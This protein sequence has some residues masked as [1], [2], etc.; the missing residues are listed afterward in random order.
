M[1]RSTSTRVRPRSLLAAAVTLLAFSAGCEKAPRTLAVRDPVQRPGDAR[2]RVQLAGVT[3]RAFAGADG[4]DLV[5]EIE[6][7]PASRLLLA[8]GTERSASLRCTTTLERDG[9]AP[10]VVA[11]LERSSAEVGWL[12]QIAALPAIDAGALRLACEGPTPSR[13]G[14]PLLA[15]L[16]PSQAAPLLVLVS[17]DLLRADHVSGFGKRSELTPRLGRLG[18]HGLRMREVASDGAR[19]LPS[20]HALF[21]SK[22]HGPWSDDSR[23][24]PLAAVLAEHGVLT[25][26]LTSGSQLRTLAEGFDHFA[27]NQPSFAAVLQRA[28]SWIDASEGIA[29]FLFLHSDAPVARGDFEPPAYADRVRELDAQI[30]ALIDRLTREAERRPVLLV[31]TSGHGAALRGDRDPSLFDERIRVPLIA[32]SPGFVPAGRTSD[33]P[34]S[35]SDIAPTLLAAAGLQLPEAMT[36]A[37]LWPFWSGARDEAPAALGTLSW[38]DGTWVFRDRE[39]KLIVRTALDEPGRYAL[40]DLSHDADERVDLASEEPEALR[41]MRERLGARLAQVG[42]PPDLPENPIAGDCVVGE[43]GCLRAQG[44]PAEPRERLRSLGYLD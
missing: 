4:A 28:E 31:V 21:H 41:L 3:K 14:Q 44:M 8:A 9:R 7:L 26:G 39:Y 35:L 22:I 10:V 40:Y 23:S 37:N 34:S 12:E 36:G 27:E 19:T 29:T 17:L 30:G 38:D 13:W 42:L 43:P 1:K 24:K 16:M 32:W 18:R 5:L 15:A 33:R 25:V 11:R 2:D 20:H 6:D